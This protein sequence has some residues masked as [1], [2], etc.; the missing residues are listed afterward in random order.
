MLGLL[1]KNTRRGEYSFNAILRYGAAGCLIVLPLM[2]LSFSA[3]ADTT[4][5]FAWDAVDDSR[6]DHYE[7]NYGLASGQYENQIITNLTDISIDLIGYEKTYYIAVRACD[8]AN[9]VCSDYSNE[10]SVTTS[11]KHNP[12]V[13]DFSASVSSGIAP[14]SVIFSEQSIGA[15]T[16]RNW[17]F[18]DGETS[19]AGTAVHT[20]TAPGR[21][22]VSLTVSG[23]DGSDSE[24]KVALI[25]VQEAAD[26]D[27]GTTDA[28]NVG[29]D[30]VMNFVVDDSVRDNAWRVAEIYIATMSY[31][32]DAEGLEY[33][34]N[35]IDNDSA[36]DPT[37]VAQSFFDQ[38]LV[39]ELYPAD[40]DDGTFIEALYFNVFGREVDS[41]G[42]Y[43]WL[44]ELQSGRLQRNE[45]I[46][47]L[48]EGGWVNADAVSD[49]AR[50]ANRVEVA[51]SFSDYQSE[52]GI[53]YGAL[54]PQNQAYLRQVGQDVLNSVTDD[55]ATRD[56]AI[57][58]IPE[59]LAALL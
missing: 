3:N 33:W 51:L 30:T 5:T 45:M 28:T 59:R 31:A 34:V 22:T 15:V 57:A 40:M 20:Y 21:Y 4:V 6:V 9:T 58:S 19:G 56:S 49:M 7:L 18:G 50:F 2:L 26:S 8:S 52:Y 38:T 39:Q 55:A 46:I 44:D 23:P 37:R 42:Y 29:S 43:Y 41:A 47:A 1:E 53:G 17:S 24:T 16:S 48:I 25:N 54:T 13:A 32:P 35:R 36:W 11:A 12:L 14:L 10:V 27:S